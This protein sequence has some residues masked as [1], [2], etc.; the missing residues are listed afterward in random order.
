[1]GAEMKIYNH[2]IELPAVPFPFLVTVSTGYPSKLIGLHKARC[3]AKDLGIKVG[4]KVISHKIEEIEIL[5]NKS[6]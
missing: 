2:T 5:E 3:L 1:M 6:K 4:H